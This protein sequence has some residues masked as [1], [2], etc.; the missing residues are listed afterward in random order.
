MELKYKINIGDGSAIPYSPTIIDNIAYIC[1]NS[2]DKVFSAVDLSKGEEM[3]SFTADFCDGKYVISQGIAYFGIRWWSDEI[4]GNEF[5]LCAINLKDGKEKW[6]VKTNGQIDNLQ[7]SNKIIYASIFDEDYTYS[8]STINIDTQKI[9]WET[10]VEQDICC[11]P[12]ISNDLCFIGLENSVCAFDIQNGKEK[13]KCDNDTITKLFSK[14]YKEIST[15][16]LVRVRDIAISDDNV[17]I[18]ADI[19]V[20]LNESYGSSSGYFSVNMKMGK[21]KHEFK[22]LNKFSSDQFSSLSLLKDSGVVYAGDTGSGNPYYNNFICIDINSGEEKWR[23][24]PGTKSFDGGFNSVP[25]IFEGIVYCGSQDQH[26]YAIDQC[27]G[28]EK[29]RLKTDYHVDGTPVIVEDTLYLAG[30]D[31]YFYAVDL[32]L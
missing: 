14:D 8:L 25:L 21:Q 19:E 5:A 16:C 24:D 13:W 28:E 32:N 6:R 27:S 22:E 18:H 17:L 23:F 9:I 20:H 12:V 3:W 2:S 4:S 1:I 15:D 29:W 30:N 7:I 11:G 31:G 26:L 10:A